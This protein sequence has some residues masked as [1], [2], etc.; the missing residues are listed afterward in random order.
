MA[1]PA[2]ATA[3]NDQEWLAWS[4]EHP[5]GSVVKCKWLTCYAGTGLAGNG[6][7]FAGGDWKNPEC[8]QFVDDGEYQRAHGHL[9]DEDVEKIV[10]ECGI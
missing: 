5:A 3:M 4:S 1:R 7:C 8:P 2:T 9:T 10:Q 6:M